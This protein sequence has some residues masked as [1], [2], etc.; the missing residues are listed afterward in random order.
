MLKSQKS[1]RYAVGGTKQLSGAAGT[2]RR[3]V[4]I[5]GR[6]DRRPYV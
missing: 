5:L 2:G 6:I 4:V 1:Q 3:S